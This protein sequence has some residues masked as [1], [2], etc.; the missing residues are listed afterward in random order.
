MLGHDEVDRGKAG[1]SR[2][3]GGRHASADGQLRGGTQGFRKTVEEFSYAST[4]LVGEGLTS[5]VYRG[6]NDGTGTAWVTQARS[7][8]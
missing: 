3:P 6:T 7:S 5:K 8:A 1:K 4:D 2:R